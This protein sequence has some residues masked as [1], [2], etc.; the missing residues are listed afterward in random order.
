AE[1]RKNAWPLHGHHRRGNEP[2][3]PLRHEL[4]RGHQ[5]A[6]DVWLC[7]TIRRG[8]VALCGPGEI[9]SA[10]RLAAASVCARLGA[11]A[12]P[13]ELYLV[14]LRAYRPVA[15]RDARHR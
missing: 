12:T 6:G 2:L 15:L 11:P 1:C 3:V 5:Y 9:A 4:S 7:R 13:A 14:L 10:V 8:L